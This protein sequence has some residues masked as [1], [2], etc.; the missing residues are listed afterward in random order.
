MRNYK[1]K[2]IV[3]IIYQFVMLFYSLLFKKLA[4]IFSNIHANFFTSLQKKYC[5]CIISYHL[6]KIELKLPWDI[7]KRVKIII[8]L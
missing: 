6:K 4:L 5:I 1:N 8:S 7:L 3:N 2:C